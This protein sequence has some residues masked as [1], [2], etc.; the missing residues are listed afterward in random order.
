MGQ[1]QL[2]NAFERA[3]AAVLDDRVKAAGRTDLPVY[4]GRREG[5]PV[6]PYAVFLVKEMDET[7]RAAS[8][9]EAECRLV[10]VTD[11]AD[12]GGSSHDEYA[13]FLENA[14]SEVPESGESDCY[15]VSLY[16]WVCYRVAEAV[17]EEDKV[18]G[19]VFSIRAGVGRTTAVKKDLGLS[20]SGG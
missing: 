5:E 17:D 15:D 10:L 19:D 9:Y 6:P 1:L 11:L 14:L 7:T 13:A 8:V 16:G 2:K 18:H 3:F 12:A 4:S 20:E